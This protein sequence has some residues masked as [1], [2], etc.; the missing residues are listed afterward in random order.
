[1]NCMTNTVLAHWPWGWEN[2]WE[3]DNEYTYGVQWTI[4]IQ[5]RTTF[6]LALKAKWETYCSTNYKENW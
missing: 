3:L 2:K 6:C 1:L 4:G 5:K